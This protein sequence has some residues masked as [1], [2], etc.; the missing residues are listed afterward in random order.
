MSIGGGALAKGFYAHPIG[1]RTL[2]CLN[3][4]ENE[5]LRKRLLKIGE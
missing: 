2:K 3:G 1:K 5:A 4:R